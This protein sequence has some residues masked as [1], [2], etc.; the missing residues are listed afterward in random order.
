MEYRKIHANEIGTLL[1]LDTY[2]NKNVIINGLNLLNRPS[3]HNSIISYV[4]NVKFID[5][6]ADNPNIKAILVKE[7]IFDQIN[8]TLK[9]I[10]L[11]VTDKPEEK[12]YE[13]HQKLYDSDIFYKKQFVKPKI[14]VNCKISPNVHIENNVEIGDNVSIGYN[15][16]IKSGSI[17]GENTVIGCN[18]IIGSEGFQ[19]I[20]L[21]DNK[22]ITVPH[23]GGCYIG[24]N[25]FISD[26]VLICNS[27]FED[28][29]YIGDGTKFDNMIHIAHNTVIG[30][31]CVITAGVV[32]CGSVTVE[33]NVWIAPN[34]TL[35]NKITLGENSFVGLGSV[36]IRDVE[37]ND[38]VCGN[39]A[40]TL[41][42]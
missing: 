40:K 5:K 8:N 29:T 34:S 36:V 39:P 28:T 25:V 10:A 6:V 18:V 26:G 17:I 4:E 23:V 32:F 15:T 24:K 13:L 9:G 22:K 3:K 11:L 33:D 31:N 16:I 12:F 2:G 30:K 1:G 14:G 42:K 37:P 27:L 38:R 19:A 35:L 21:S 7:D 20:N 41:R